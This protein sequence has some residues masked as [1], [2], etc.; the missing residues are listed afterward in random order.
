MFIGMV[1]QILESSL[2]LKDRLLKIQGMGFHF[3]KVKKSY[4]VTKLQRKQLRKYIIIIKNDEQPE[5][6]I[7]LGNSQCNNVTLL[8]F[9]L[10]P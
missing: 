2:Q 4:K 1:L 5:A 10:S 6:S 3:G 7:F 8:Q 9:N